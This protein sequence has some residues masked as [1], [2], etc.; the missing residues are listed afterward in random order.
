[1]IRQNHKFQ[2]GPKKEIT[3]ILFIWLLFTALTIFLILANIKL[4]AH[5]E[6]VQAG[7]LDLS[8]QIE[9]LKKEI[10]LFDS[11]ISGKFDP[12]YLEKQAREVLNLKKAGEQ[13]VIILNSPSETKESQNI[14][15][16]SDKLDNLFQDL[17]YR[18]RRFFR[19]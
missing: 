16:Q 7:I 13:A 4:K 8:L 3:G 2:K 15:R 9:V 1:M 12:F 10:A 17:I 11:K 18:I 5:R 14:E 19:F 6:R